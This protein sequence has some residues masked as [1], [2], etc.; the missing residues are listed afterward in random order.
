MEVVLREWIKAVMTAVCCSETSVSALCVSWFIFWL[1]I[2]VC[3]FMLS[4]SFRLCL[5]LCLVLCSQF[6]S[7]WFGVFEPKKPLEAKT[8][9]TCDVKLQAPCVVWAAGWVESRVRKNTN[10]F[11]NFPKSGGFIGGFPVILWAKGPW[12]ESYLMSVSFFSLFP[13]F[14]E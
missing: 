13:C 1:R 5:L 3:V 12:I 4:A 6:A 7:G 2:K 10:H 8:E 9:R 14:V 11:F